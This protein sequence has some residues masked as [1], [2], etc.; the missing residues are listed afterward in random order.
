M[1]KIKLELGSYTELNERQVS[2]LFSDTSDE[3]KLFDGGMTIEIKFE[4]G[5]DRGAFWLR[6]AD[7]CTNA[8]Q[9]IITLGDDQISKWIEVVEQDECDII[10]D[11]TYYGIMPSDF[12]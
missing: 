4:T 3:M 12:M 10:D 2:A 1:N 11:Y 8:Y 7:N 6:C 5:L 9:R